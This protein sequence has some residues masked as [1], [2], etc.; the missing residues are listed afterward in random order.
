M[1]FRVDSRFPDAAGDELGVLRT[2]IEDKNELVV[3]HREG[4]RIPDSH[5]IR[6]FICFSNAPYRPPPFPVRRRGALR[7]SSRT[8]GM[9]G[10]VLS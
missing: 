10:I 9:S 4:I 1:K 7:K 8:A 5:N 6:I 3:D 2:V